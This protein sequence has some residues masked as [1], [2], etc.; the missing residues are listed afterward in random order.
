MSPISFPEVLSSHVYL[1]HASIIRVANSLSRHFVRTRLLDQRPWL[2][3]VTENP[4]QHIYH[5][6]LHDFRIYV[7]TYS[8]VCNDQYAD[9]NNRNIYDVVDLTSTFNGNL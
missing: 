1:I 3:A 8:I 9:K 5:G 7:L 6:H 4:A 2:H